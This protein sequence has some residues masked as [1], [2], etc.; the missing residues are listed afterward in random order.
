MW[1]SLKNIG[2]PTGD[3]RYEV[4]R[5]LSFNGNHHPKITSVELAENGF[6]YNSVYEKI[7]CYFCEVELQSSK[8]SL[9]HGH[10]CKF[11]ISNQQVYQYRDFEE[12]FTPL[13]SQSPIPEAVTIIK[14]N[15]NDMHDKQK[16][17][18]TFENCMKYIPVKFTDLAENGFYYIRN[19]DVIKCASCSFTIQNSKLN[20]DVMQEHKQHCS[21]CPYVNPS[22]KIELN[23]IKSF[24][25]STADYRLK[26]H[27]LAENGF[28]HKGPRDNACCIFCKCEINEWNANDNIKEKHLVFSPNCPFLAGELVGNEPIQVQNISFDRPQHPH[29]ALKLDRLNTFYTWPKEKNQKPNDLVDAGFFY[30]GKSDTVVCF[31][32]NGGLNNWDEFDEPWSEHIKWFPKCAFV[33]QQKSKFQSNSA[34]N[35]AKE[36]PHTQLLNDEVDSHMDTSKNQ[37]ISSTVLKSKHRSIYDSPLVLAVITMGYNKQLVKRTIREK[38]KQTGSCFSQASSLLEAIENKTYMNEEQDSEEDSAT[39][40]IETPTV[41]NNSGGNANA[42]LLKENEMLKEIKLC[43]ICL[44]EELSIVFLPCGHLI[45]CTYCAP[46]LAECPMCREKIHGVVK[47][48]F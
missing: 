32:C 45:S 29:F 30:T 10:S 12:D 20:D 43:K 13:P 40:E 15:E 3:Y 9:K 42:D 22:M 24:T 31:S 16:R 8:F 11:N 5:I 17:L 1:N 14:L 28:Y 36:T 26:T 33:R 37:N 47:T 34:Q 25:R 44:D 21:E 27:L 39:E 19:N 46:A 41:K 2:T 35:F 48:F 6:Y 23:R 7:M 18:S 38:I 4:E